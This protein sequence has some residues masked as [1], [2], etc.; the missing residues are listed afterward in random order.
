VVT[1]KLGG[2]VTALAIIAGPRYALSLVISVRHLIEDG[3]EI[4]RQRLRTFE[5]TPFMRLCAFQAAAPD[6]MRWLCGS[7]FPQTQKECAGSRWS[8]RSGHE[9][10]TSLIRL[11][12]RRCTLGR[13][14]RQRMPNNT[15][16]SFQFRSREADASG[17][18]SLLRHWCPGRG[19][20]GAFRSEVETTPGLTPR[21]AGCGH[22]YGWR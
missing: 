7:L 3:M 17:S 20:T 18:L 21:G 15:A 19:Y 16:G 1:Q 13:H 5:P 9:C 10:L 14:W 4:R 6:T 8:G 12:Q 11:R 22:A 2:N